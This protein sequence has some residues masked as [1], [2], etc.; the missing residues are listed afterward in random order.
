VAATRARELLVVSRWTG[1]QKLKAW[2]VL[3]D[4]LT[5]AKEL[6]IPQ[7]VAAPSLEPLDCSTEPQAEFIAVRIRAHE[8]TRRASWSIT[9]ATADAQHIVRATRSADATPDD[10]TKVVATDTPTH[11]ADAGMAWGTLVHGL[12]EHAMRHR[13]V[14]SEDLRRLAMWLTVDEPQLRT[15]LDDAVETVQRVAKEEF[16]RVAKAGEH[17]E[18]APFAFGHSG[19]LTNGVI[20]LLYKS[21]G[22]WRVRDYK[23]DVTLSQ[24][25]YDKQLET[26]RTALRQIGYE[27]NDAEVVSVRPKTVE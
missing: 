26:Y 1:N 23:T 25:A 16:W 27:V 15:V 11:R 8:Q 18:E 13:D 4:F 14:T 2:G 17:A 7:T 6:P 22:S 20:D 12:L 3:N 19:T 21:A 10:P 9:S 5:G 24:G